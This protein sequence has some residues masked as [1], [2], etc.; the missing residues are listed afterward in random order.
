[1]AGGEGGKDRR[2]VRQ[3]ERVVV[4]TA[5]RACPRIEQ[6]KGAG[7]VVELATDGRH[8]MLDQSFHQLMP[9]RRIGV[10]HLLGVLVGAAR[11][12]LDEVAGDGERRP[13]EGQERHR[14]GKLG[15]EHVDRLQ[16]VRGVSRG[17]ERPQPA[18][19]VGVTQRCLADRTRAGRHVDAEPDGVGGNDDVAVEHGG[20]DAVA[21]HGLQGELGGTVRGCLMASR[22]LP[23]PRIA[24]YS[25]RL[26]PAW[27]MNHTGVCV[28]R[29]PFAAR[30]NGAVDMREARYRSA[31]R[32]P[33]SAR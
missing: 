3:H 20:V 9:Q 17:L 15:G 14:L 22:M 32:G 16:H 23:S 2:R 30:M 5:E 1:M 28:L 19:I 11:P 29:R 8:G 27:R 18:Q 33:R 13:G 7:S 4:G 12:A 26:R 24:R 6:L 10:H 31:R 25:G 21:A